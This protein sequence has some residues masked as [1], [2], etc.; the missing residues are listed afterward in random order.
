MWSQV[1]LSTDCSQLDGASRE[2]LRTHEMKEAE[3][4]R[5]ALH[6]VRGERRHFWVLE[7]LLDE[8]V[9]DPVLKDGEVWICG[10]WGEE[11][12]KWEM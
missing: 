11:E 10:L 9:L 12:G 8:V 1:P 6:T 3:K 4:C 7:N 5:L 2:Y